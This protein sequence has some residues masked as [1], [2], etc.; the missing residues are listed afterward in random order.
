MGSPATTIN[1]SIFSKICNIPPQT[2]KS[3]GSLCSLK[4]MCNVTLHQSMGGWKTKQ[5]FHEKKQISY[6]DALAG[7]TTDLP[8]IPLV[9]E[10]SAL[11]PVF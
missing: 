3:Y 11:P 4:L 10:V 6:Q 9:R 8:A 2:P 1:V 7:N 5:I